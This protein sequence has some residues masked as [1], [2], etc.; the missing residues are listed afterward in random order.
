MNSSLSV[1]IIG[2]LPDLVEQNR[3][4]LESEGYAVT[5]E[6]PEAVSDVLASLHASA[7]CLIIV[8]D[9]HLSFSVLELQNE[10]QQHDLAIPL[11]ALLHDSAA[12]SYR[13]LLSAGIQ[14]VLSVKHLDRLTLT[15]S[16]ILR[17][18]ELERDRN[19]FQRLFTNNPLPMYIYAR[20]TL[21]FLEVNDAAVAKYGYSRDEFLRMT[22][23]DIRPPDEVAR[24]MGVFA[25][26][27]PILSLYD[28][29]WRHRLKDGTMIDVDITDHAIKFA[30][31]AAG[32]VVAIDVTE[33]K[34]AELALRES[35][36]QFKTLIEHAPEAIMI[37]DRQGKYIQVNQRACDLFGYTREQFLTLYTT[38][39]VLPGDESGSHSRIADLFAG[40]ILISER[41]LI[42]KDGSVVDTIVSARALDENRLVALVQD[43]SELKSAEEALI[44]SE[45]RYRAIVESQS[46]MVM[47]WL[48]DGR[49]SFANDA[50]YNFLDLERDNNAV[51]NIFDYVYV[52]DRDALRAH[53]AQLSQTSPVGIHEN[54][55]VLPNG[56]VRWTHWSNRAIYDLDGALIEVQSVGNDITERKQAEERSAFLF[57]LLNATNAASGQE[58][59]F[60][61]TLQLICQHH[62]WAYGEVWLPTAD[63][64]MLVPSAAYYIEPSYREALK[65]L[66]TTTEVTRFPKG[67][68]G[69]GRALLTKAIEWMDDLTQ[70]SVE[71][72]PRKPFMEAVGMYTTIIM[73]IVAM[74]EVIAVVQFITTGKVKENQR[75][76][77]LLKASINQ[78]GTVILRKRAND[79]L[80]LDEERYRSLLQSFDSIILMLDVNGNI[81]YANE[82]GWQRFGI[83]TEQRKDKTLFDVFPPEDAK[84][85]IAYCKQVTQTE[86]GLTEERFT[87]LGGST[88]WLHMSYQ[89]VHNGTVD[90]RYILINAS[91]I[92]QLK[93]A[94]ESLERAAARLQILHS[95]DS[96]I[97]RAQSAQEIAGSAL[98]L[99]QRLIPYQRGAIAMMDT[100][101]RTGTN[102]ARTGFELT[103]QRF[104]DGATF[105]ISSAI[106]EVIHQRYVLMSSAEDARRWGPEYE[107]IF[108]STTRTLLLISMKVT[109][110]LIALMGL[111]AVTVDAFTGEHIEIALE[112]ADQLAIA[113]TQARL[114]D[115]IQAYASDLEARVEA[116]T[117]EVAHAKTRIETILNTSSDGILVVDADHLIQELNPV[118]G[119]LFA[120]SEESYIGQRVTSLVHPHDRN[121]VDEAITIAN[122]DIDAIQLIE[123][124]ALRAD[125]T[126]FDAEI[127]IASTQRLNGD[128][129][130]YVCNLR[131]ISARKRTEELLRQ[132]LRQEKELSELKTRFIS[133]A[134]HEFRT[135]LATIRAATDTLGAY[136]AKMTEAQINAR[137]EKIQNQVSHLTDIM[138][139]VLTVARIQAKRVTFS[140]VETDVDEF[141]REIIDEVLAHPDLNRVINYQCLVQ[142]KLI[143]LD[144]M[145]MRKIL[146]NLIGN[147]VK[148]SAADKP[149][150]VML[151]S[152]AVTLMLRVQDYGIGIP[153]ADQVHLFEAFHR[154][155]NVGMTPGTGLGLTIVK[156]AVELHGGTLSFESQ[157]G[158]GTTFIVAI[159]LSLPTIGKEE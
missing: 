107:A 137:L 100:E 28:K 157:V 85:L 56:E 143:Q 123:V 139:E 44:T 148:Y 69:P 122:H 144:R 84:Q 4:E 58:S 51:L 50:Y 20:G 41:Q 70:A 159:P 6:R 98:I 83:P 118:V 68:G 111:H 17:D 11:L 102:L 96:A 120:C 3:Q 80:R 95:I 76:L 79:K 61:T 38:D 37:T 24:L 14:D 15:V 65:A 73:P 21:D 31:Q 136:R 150:E 64:E 82:V 152:D 91:D 104:A 142:N 141:C 132:A 109:D 147:A 57:Q 158:I 47:R 113:F 97:L 30:G 29:S 54:R 62:Q 71:K 127:G 1:L 10:L 90:I 22:L 52:E 66:R 101:A 19:V 154:A 110:S 116:R 99:I 88:V 149:V 125:G 115:Q 108:R 121:L 16:R 135:P 138:D 35:E 89:P 34:R 23:K 36:R 130:T 48:L 60:Y 151:S 2:A 156:Q 153:D 8:D 59:A 7:Y 78:L 27:R 72:F 134:S 119:T 49:L 45:Q 74:D 43:I 140:P 67:V 5:S 117:A 18:Y 124:R 9:S 106:N 33:R 40:K 46:E 126:L 155:S 81:S 53:C 93:Y 42:R 145:L 92:S 55:L 12:S 75:Q 77:A 103:D 39:L 25:D 63:G 112:V 87:N 86:R 133:M 131:N 105:N 26:E 129:L 146:S 94:E 128:R 32:L 114:N 13:R